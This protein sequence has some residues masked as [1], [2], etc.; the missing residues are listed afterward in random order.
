MKGLNR[1]II[2]PRDH[3]DGLCSKQSLEDITSVKLQQ[4]P[5]RTDSHWGCKKH[6]CADD[7]LE[8]TIGRG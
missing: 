7:S 2:I 5:E 3:E 8:V 6:D 1:P 4:M